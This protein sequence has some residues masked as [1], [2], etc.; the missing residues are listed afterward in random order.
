MASSSFS[1]KREIMTKTKSMLI[2]VE[3]LT[4]GSWIKAAESRKNSNFND[5]NNIVIEYKAYNKWKN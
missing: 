4:S 1:N 2:S 5:N 3:M